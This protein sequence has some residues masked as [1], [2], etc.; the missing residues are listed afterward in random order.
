MVTQRLRR[1]RNGVRSLAFYARTPWYRKLVPEAQQAFQELRRSYP[2][3][4]SHYANYVNDA[5]TGFARKPGVKTPEFLRFVRQLEDAYHQNVPKQ[6]GHY[7]FLK[8]G[9]AFLRFALQHP[10]P[11]LFANEHVLHNVLQAAQ[12]NP[13]APLDYVL[14]WIQENRAHTRKLEADE[15]HQVWE[16]VYASHINSESI[17]QAARQLVEHVHSASFPMRGKPRVS[18]IYVRR[19][20]NFPALLF[21]HALQKEGFHKDVDYVVR[22]IKPSRSSPKSAPVIPGDDLS[23]LLSEQSERDLLVFVD[24]VSKT[25][26]TKREVNTVLS[27]GTPRLWVH[28]GPGA[29]I[30]VHWLSPPRQRRDVH[31]SSAALFNLSEKNPHVAGEHEEGMHEVPLQPILRRA[32]TRAFQAR[33]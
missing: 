20:G 15:V 10:R 4:A 7:A 5:K 33:H 23:L 2:G 27:Q 24:S 19:G 8:A 16:D 28:Q 3:L 9:D 31:A 13:R 29:D 22:S 11:H 30:P 18:L 21:Q 17:R 12:L 25:G 14:Q 1:L 26:A 32:I 6:A